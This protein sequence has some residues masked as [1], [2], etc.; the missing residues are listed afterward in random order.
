MKNPEKTEAVA[1]WGS[2]AIVLT[3]VLNMFVP[4][5]SNEA[6]QV[7]TDAVV[8]FGPALFAIWRARS[9]VYSEDT[10]NKMALRPEKKD[11]Q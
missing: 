9:K 4:D 3:T 5:V 1:F 6:L 7:L 10:V 11:Y 2:F 8:N